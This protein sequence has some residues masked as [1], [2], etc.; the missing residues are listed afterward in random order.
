MLSRGL[1]I[2]RSFRA[3]EVELTLSEI[4]RRTDLPKATAHRL[5]GELVDAGMLERAE[6]GLRLGLNLFAL[7]TRVPRHRIMRELALPHL[8][9]VHEITRHTVFLFLADGG[10]GA[11]AESRGAGGSRTSALRPAE[12][13]A[14]A[15]ATAKVFRAYGPPPDAVDTGSGERYGVRG[16]RRGGRRLAPEELGRVVEQGFAVH[17]GPEAVAVAVPVVDITGSPVAAL[18]AA[19][20][21]DRLH[22]LKT[23]SL[24]RAASAELSRNLRATPGLVPVP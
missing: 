9:R 18:A 7:G 16:L 8:N 15:T 17:R 22:L 4:A 19:G 5:I 24:L 21:P 3:D 6:R 2:L 23:A 1:S 14:S 12:I 13:E 10:D 20:I 11:M